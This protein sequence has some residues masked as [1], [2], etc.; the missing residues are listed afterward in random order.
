MITAEEPTMADKTL[1]EKL[2]VMLPH[3][4]E[5]NEEHIA[6]MQKYL[7]ALETE[8]QTALAGGCSATITQMNRV[9]DALTAMLALLDT[10]SSRH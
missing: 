10:P 2:T 8:G 7:H 1:T 5:H 3:W 4:L 6:E 9:S